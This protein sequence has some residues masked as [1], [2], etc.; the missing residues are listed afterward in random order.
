M[1]MYIVSLIVRSYDDIARLSSMTTCLCLMDL[2][3]IQEY[4]PERYLTILIVRS[5][6][7]KISPKQ[8]KYPLQT[9]M[10]DN[11]PMWEA[12]MKINFTPRSAIRKTKFKVRLRLFPFT[13]IE[14]ANEWFQSLVRNSI[15]TWEELKSIILVSLTDAWERF[16]GLLLNLSNHGISKQEIVKIFYKGLTDDSRLTLDTSSR[17]IFEYKSAKEAYQLLE[18]MTIHHLDWTPKHEEKLAIEEVRLVQNM[19]KHFEQ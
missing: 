8:G 3:L 15:R 5:F 16:K 12:R 7:D 14:G 6:D 4:H 9:R 10:A 13:L 17:G 2:I 1:D 18:D 11:Q 19:Q